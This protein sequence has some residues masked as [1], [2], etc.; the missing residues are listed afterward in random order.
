MAGMARATKE[1]P[2]FTSGAGKEPPLEGRGY[3]ESQFSENFS[4]SGGST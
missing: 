4:I 1:S 3:L 2:D